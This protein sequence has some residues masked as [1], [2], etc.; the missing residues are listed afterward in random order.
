MPGDI[1]D[2]LF[3]RKALKKAEKT[4]EKKAPENKGDAGLDM[5]KL[6]QEHADRQLKS[7]TSSKAPDKSIKKMPPKGG[8]RY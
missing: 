6:A 7:K 4:G 1:S 8:K 5:A 3:G 2:F